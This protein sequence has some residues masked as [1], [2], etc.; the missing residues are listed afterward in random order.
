M[1][2]PSTQTV[3][4]KSINLKN[5]TSPPKTS[6]LCAASWNNRVSFATPLFQF[7]TYW[8]L[9]QCSWI[10]NQKCEYCP[11][12]ASFPCWKRCPTRWAQLQVISCIIEHSIILEYSAMYFLNRV[13]P[14]K[15]WLIFPRF[16]WILAIHNSQRK[17]HP[18][19]LESKNQITNRASSC[20]RNFFGSWN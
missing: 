13:R 8:C 20:L 14:R 1:T 18:V 11:V 6:T 9:L 15:Y 16:Y 2:M 17:R 12:C 10:L 3:G 7:E 5:R 19:L 4:S